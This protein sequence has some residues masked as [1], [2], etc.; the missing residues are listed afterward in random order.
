MAASSNLRF[1]PYFYFRFGRKRPSD[2]VFRNF[3]PFLPI[4]VQD[5]TS[6]ECYSLVGRHL[7]SD[8]VTSGVAQTGSSF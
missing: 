8:D 4:I 7:A 1:P 3:S 5:I 6:E 2:G